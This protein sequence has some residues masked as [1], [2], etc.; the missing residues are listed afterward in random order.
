MTDAVLAQ[1]REAYAH[2]RWDVAYTHFAEVAT[3]EHLDT[4]DL[5]A[6]AD[7]AWW[8]G[9]TD[10]SL[11]L[12]EEV[13][14][15]CLQGDHTPTAARLAVEIGFLWLIR[16]EQQIGSGW[17]SRARR[18]LA[19][20]P[21]CAELGYLRYLAVLEA[22]H[23]VRFDEARA[24]AREMQSLA[25]TH[26]DPTL[27]AMALVLEGIATVRSGQV[28]DG[29][30]LCDE[31]MLPIRAGDVERS[32]AGNLYCL[33]M[34]L[35]FELADFERARAWTDAT[36]R[37]CDQFSNAAMFTGICRVHRAQLLHLD[38]AWDQAESRA[39]QACRDLADMN[40][41]VVAAGHYEIGELR[42]VRG[43]DD[44]AEQAFARA[45]ALGRDPQPGLALLR[46]AQGETATARRSLETALAAT[47]P[48]LPRVPL[49]AALA[50]VA[51]AT[52][53]PS[54]AG[55]VAA[56]LAESAATFRTPGIQARAA[57]AAGVAHLL[58][59]EPDQALV[60][61][62]EACRAWRSVGGRYETARAQVRLARALAAIGDTDAARREREQATV[63]FETLGARPDLAAVA[64]AGHM[65]ARAAPGGLTGREVEVLRL[66]AEGASNAV[67]AEQL[68]ISERTVERHISNIFL[69]LGVSS[70][71][72][73]ARFAFEHG[74]VGENA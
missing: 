50:D 68:T 56:E 16:G 3:A 64:A 32:W 30:A 6:F 59:D 35:C 67:V 37:W 29:L 45:H 28:T 2:H 38:G 44:G 58:A 13:Y 73:A 65:T 7:A 5:A 17:I 47:E 33:V 62:R 53:D 8:L 74:L 54:L 70:R 69:K 71:T 51:E 9:D 36:E 57:A 61:L 26:D 31:A 27:C 48:P 23:A 49:L 42:R 12:S 43:D 18:L 24:M 39:A 52:Q 14:R 4:D 11:E 46:L 63:T 20:V 40:V 55:A 66:V 41:E 1:A 10:R 72:Q 22:L 34:A 60:T 21:E 19:E 25:T 15:R